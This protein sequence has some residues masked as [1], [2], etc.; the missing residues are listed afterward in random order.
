M[1]LGLRRLDDRHALRARRGTARRFRIQLA[2]PSQPMACQNRQTRH[3]R[4]GQTQAMGQAHD[5]S[6]KPFPFTHQWHHSSFAPSF[7]TVLPTP[8]FQSFLGRVGPSRVPRV[9][10]R[11]TRLATCPS[12]AQ[13]ARTRR[14]QT[15]TLAIVAP[16]LCTDIS[17]RHQRK[18]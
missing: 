17:V 14:P 13:A 8:C 1:A 4:M 12:L 2:L 7:R 3:R 11:R 16:S 9:G 15:R 10:R 5:A 6:C 18:G